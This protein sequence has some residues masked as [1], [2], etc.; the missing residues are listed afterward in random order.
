[1]SI[2]SFQV[3]ESHARARNEL[4]K[5]TKRLQLSAVIFGVILL[6]IGWGLNVYLGGIM[7]TIVLA[8]FA[9]MAMVSFIIA[10]ILP[11]KVGNAQQL[12]DNYHLCP[13]II[14]KVNPR[15]M[16]LLSLVNLNTDESAPP[17]W[18]LAARTVTRIEGH[19]RQQGQKVPSVAIT[20]RRS[21]KNTSTW[22]EISPMPIAWGTTDQ[23]VIEEARKAIPHE[24]WALLEK[25]TDRL[26]EVLK[27][28]FNLLP[29]D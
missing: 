23:E 18:G 2:F 19:E 14:A 10:L 15:D 6:A 11:G 24:Q 28:R 13:A 16:A 29:L 12:Y 5:D 21:M 27:T 7:G 8:S 3:D 20:G 17:R 1:M 25:N 22:D 4:L 9:L 26:D